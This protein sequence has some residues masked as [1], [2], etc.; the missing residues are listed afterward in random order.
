MYRNTLLSLMVCALVF[1]SGVV[2]G[3]E[4]V[5]CIGGGGERQVFLD[6][7]LAWYKERNPDLKVTIADGSSAKVVTLISGGVPPELHRIGF[8]TY[9]EFA[10]AGYLADIGAYINRSRLD[11]SIF[12][13][14]LVQA[15]KY[16][17]VYYGLPSNVNPDIVFW[18]RQ[19]FAERGVAPPPVRYG[20]SDWN[21]QS[22]RSMSKKL[23]IDADGDGRPEQWGAM[24]VKGL[25]A[26]DTFGSA[27]GARWMNEQGQF[28]GNQSQMIAALQFLADWLNQDRTAIE[29]GS[30]DLYGSGKA[31]MLIGSAANRVPSYETTGLPYGVAPSPT[32]HVPMLRGAVIR[33]IKGSDVEAAWDFALNLVTNPYWAARKAIA[34]GG[35]PS[36]RSA[37]AEYQKLAT[38]VT[39]EMVAT[40]VDQVTM[41]EIGGPVWGPRYTELTGTVT[42]YVQNIVNNTTSARI[43]ME[44]AAGEIRGILGK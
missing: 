13:D 31:A 12:F 43:A 42:K 14:P 32:G 41:G 39:P 6:D 16:K 2:S 40:F 5:F 22:I 1:T 36:V 3:K 25:G 24:M 37:F 18:N 9:A 35:V 10:S 7:Y 17:G 34:Y 44:Q 19:L 27:W 38:Y 33:F 26:Q 11:L 30:T 28:T 29:Q 4:I 20:Q 23:T 21:W 8:E 15:I